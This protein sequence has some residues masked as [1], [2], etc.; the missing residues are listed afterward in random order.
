MK[1]LQWLSKIAKRCGKSWRNPSEFPRNYFGSPPRKGK[2]EKGDP[3]KLPLVGPPLFG[4]PLRGDG[5]S[6]EQP[7]RSNERPA[8]AS[9]S[10]LAIGGV[11]RQ[12]CTKRKFGSSLQPLKSATIFAYLT[13][14]FEV[15]VA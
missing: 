13:A 7:G 1:E 2:S 3:E 5:G 11:G 10:H 8:R 12:K 14:T 6:N 9:S 15:K 4:S